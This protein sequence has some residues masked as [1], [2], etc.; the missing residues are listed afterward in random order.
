MSHY[1]SDAWRDDV[2]SVYETTQ[3]LR[4]HAIDK[5]DPLAHHRGHR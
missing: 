5:A 4:S 1:I 3:T 2:V